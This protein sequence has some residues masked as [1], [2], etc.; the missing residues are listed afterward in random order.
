[1]SLGEVPSAGQERRV[2]GQTISS[3]PHGEN[4]RLIQMRRVMALPVEPQQILDSSDI[5]S[6]QSEVV[7]AEGDDLMVDVAPPIERTET[8][9]LREIESYLPT[10]ITIAGEAS[11]ATSD[12]TVGERPLPPGTTKQDPKAKRLLD[13]TDNAAVTAMLDQFDEMEEGVMVIGEGGRDNRDNGQNVIVAEGKHGKASEATMKAATDAIDN[14]RH[15]ITYDPHSRIREDQL[16]EGARPLPSKEPQDVSISIVALAHGAEGIT[17]LADT[18]WQKM[19]G[20]KV[21]GLSIRQSPREII[22]AWLEASNLRTPEERKRFILTTLDR[23]DFNVNGE[24]IQAA[25]E[26]GITLDMPQGGD[27]L[28]TAFAGK[29]KDGTVRALLTRGGGPEVGLSAAIVRSLQKVK[30]LDFQARLWDA[31]PQIMAQNEVWDLDR[32]VPSED[33]VVAIGI[34]T[35]DD[36][37]SGLRGVPLYTGEPVP[38]DQKVNMI[39]TSSR[40]LELPVYQRPLQQAA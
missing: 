28:V 15:L 9:V 2:I 36:R 27:V 37:Y 39:T 19:I 40:G 34:L 23:P 24:I 3:R 10:V 13:I 38:Y 4:T 25:Q 35:D 30:D 11:L 12:A 14:T 20:P 32:V 6:P 18:H 8:P 33:V 29:N 31:D 1:M 5:M 22:E 26:A 16:V 7:L 21:E 17:E